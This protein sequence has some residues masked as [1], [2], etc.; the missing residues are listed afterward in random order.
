MRGCLDRIRGTDCA[1]FQPKIWAGDFE[2][3]I[4]STPYTSAGFHQELA[5]GTV[6]GSNTA[7]R[8]P[9][10]LSSENCLILLSGSATTPVLDLTRRSHI[11]IGRQLESD[12]VVQD[13]TCSRRHC[14]LT[15]VDRLWYAEDLFSRNGTFINGQRIYNEYPL[16][17]GD[18]V[19]VGCTR[20]QFG[21][22]SPTDV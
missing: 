13:P 22:V 17:N 20:F 16:C 21:E 7:N 15:K 5:P 18:I 8:P 11:S 9:H 1:K 12:V 19:Q 4:S 10:Y 3:A 6:R 14:L 2:M